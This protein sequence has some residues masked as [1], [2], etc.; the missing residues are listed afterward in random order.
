MTETLF[1]LVSD[2]TT[3][4]DYYTPKWLFDMLNVEFDIDVAAPVQGIPWLPAKRWF[5]QADDGLAQ[6]WAGQ[7]VWMNPPF[8]KSTPWAH[9]FLDNGNGIALMVVSRARWFATMWEQADAICSTPWD[10]AFK[11]SDGSQKTISF[12]TFLFAKGPKGVEALHNANIN[13]VR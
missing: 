13:R 9:K 4:D 6:D 10:L 8:S 3:S 5:S 11:R 12:Q 2:S 1:N 7:F